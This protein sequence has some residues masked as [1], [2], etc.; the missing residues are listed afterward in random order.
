M[1]AVSVVLDVGL[2]ITA[3]S[4]IRPEVKVRVLLR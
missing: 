2:E 4:R 3:L 1:V